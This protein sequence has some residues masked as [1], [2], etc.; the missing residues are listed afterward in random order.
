[1]KSAL[2]ARASQLRAHLGRVEGAHINGVVQAGK[3][4]SQSDASHT[5]ALTRIK[6]GSLVW[7]MNT[8]PTSKLDARLLGPFKVADSD[9]EGLD[10]SA[11]Y[12]LESL[13]GVKIDRTVPRDQ[14]VVLVPFRRCGFPKDSK[15]YTAQGS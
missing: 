4:R 12:H 7:R 3:M 2:V 1:M 13:S 5:V 14:L 6:V 11:N 15:P 10:M 8:T 9:K